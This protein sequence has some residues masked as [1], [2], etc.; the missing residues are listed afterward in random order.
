MMKWR[1]AALADLETI[2]GWAADEGWNPGAHDAEAFR[3]ADPDGFFVAVGE[4]D[5]P[6][7][8]ISVVNHTPDF[9]FLGLYIVTPNFRGRGIGL[10]LW[11][12]ALAH[13][14]DR[15]IGLD[16]VE[17]QQDNYRASGFVH[18]GGTTRFT[19]HLAGQRHSAI[20]DAAPGDVQRLIELEGRASGVKNPAQ[21]LRIDNTGRPSVFEVQSYSK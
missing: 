20:R 12:N 15:T 13:A 2:L 10:D 8:S 11:Q 17:A 21:P 5:E 4:Y 14:G 7:A 3:K 1:K 16:G 18:A 6:V 9:A 19:G